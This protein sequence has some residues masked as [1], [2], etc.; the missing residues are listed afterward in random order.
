VAAL[1]GPDD[2]FRDGR[3]AWERQYEKGAFLSQSIH[4]EMPNIAQQFQ[5]H[6]VKH[7]LDH[8]CGSG[9]HTVF[10]AQ[11]GFEVCGLD[12]APTGLQ[13]TIQKLAVLG[14]STNTTLADILHLPFQNHS[15][16]AIISIRV[17]HHN[18]IAV[19]QQY[20]KEMWRVLRPQGLIWVTVPVPKGHGSKDG[21]E[22]EPGTWVPTRGIEKGLPHHL[23]TEE[24]LRCLFQH[25][26]IQTLRTYSL[27]HYSLLAQKISDT[28]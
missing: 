14:P 25:F 7:V 18:R 21:H 17:I 28:Q 9:R 2:E 27:S 24:G 1:Q 20:V 10:L 6:G 8:G 13:T 4:S 5:E 15:F 16:D 3:L 23:F 12:I 22:I 26:E 19:I 11:H